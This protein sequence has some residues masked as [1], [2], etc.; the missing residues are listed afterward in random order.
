MSNFDIDSS[1]INILIWSAML[2][3]FVMDY[4]ACE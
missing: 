1:L 4:I 3:G 2:V